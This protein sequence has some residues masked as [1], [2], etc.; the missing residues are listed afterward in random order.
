MYNFSGN[1]GVRGRLCTVRAQR[2][3]STHSVGTARTQRGYIGDFLLPLT[4]F[5]PLWTI[6]HPHNVAQLDVSPQPLVMGGT[7]P[8]VSNDLPMP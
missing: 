6:L 5:L 1:S 7:H 2:G 8:N 3:H 4:I